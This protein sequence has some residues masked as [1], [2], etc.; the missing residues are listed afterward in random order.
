MASISLSILVE[1]RLRGGTT[2]LAG[3]NNNNNKSSNQELIKGRFTEILFLESSLGFY[4]FDEVQA[5]IQI[6]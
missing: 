6:S 3:V 5:E 1:G 4:K 2:L